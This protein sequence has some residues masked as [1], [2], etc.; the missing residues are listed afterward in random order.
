MQDRQVNYGTRARL[1]MLLPSGNVAAE[2][3]IL[4][5]LPP[6]V[7]LH[8]TRLKLTGSSPEE[9]LAMAENVEPAAMLLADARPDV[10]AFHCTA[11]ST[12]DP[13][14]DATISARIEAATGVR[15]FTTAGALI[16]ALHVLRAR[17]IVMITPYIKAINRSEIAF[18]DHHGI[19]V[20]NDFGLEIDNPQAMFDVDPAVWFDL[21]LQRRDINAD[22]FFLSCTAIRSAEIIDALEA[23]IGR[24]V[25]TSNQV[26]A[27]RALKM[28]GIED[29]IDG[30]GRL[31][32]ARP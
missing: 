14:M 8:T 31:F 18:L 12:W 32:A 27:W 1:G 30:Y 11:V 16:D 4:R 25:I 21:V 17:R 6:G 26:M 13:A 24:P 5:M 2:P 7:S 29:A 22:A 23:E 10:I 9:L 20:V 19:E 15:A 3:Q 28:A